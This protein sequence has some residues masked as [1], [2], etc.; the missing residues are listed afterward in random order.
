M[1]PHAEVAAVTDTSS[2][3]VPDPILTKGDTHAKF[4]FDD[5]LPHRQQ[6]EPV[7]TIVAAFSSAHMFKSK[8][9]A[10]KPKARKWDQHFSMESRSRQPSSLKGAMKYFKKDTIS[11]CGG[12]PSPLV[13]LNF[14]LINLLTCAVI[15]FPS[16]KW[17][18]SY[19][20]HPISLKMSWR[21]LP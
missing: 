12:L 6:S 15:I 18:P 17:V 1:A 4:T 14:G 7:S 16:T 21:R 5:V 11:L 20:S 3:V 13:F 19:R 8:K 10:N 9:S 2:V